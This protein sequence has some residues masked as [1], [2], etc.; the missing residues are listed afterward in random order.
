MTGRVG[1]RPDIRRYR[2]A[3]LTVLVALSIALWPEVLGPFARAYVRLCAFVPQRLPVGL[4]HH[5]PYVVATIL[6]AV[7]TL[8]VLSGFLLLRQLVRQRRMTAVLTPR[9]SSSEGHC[10]GIAAA[11]GVDGRLVIVDDRAVYAFCAGLLSPRIYL[12][13]GLVGMLEPSELA[14]VLHHEAAHIRQHDPLRLFLSDLLEWFTA[15][16]PVLRTLIAR[17]RIRIELAADQAALAVVP[18]DVLASALLKV[19]RARSAPEYT[20][21]VAGL[22]PSD[23]R[24]A[25]LA[26]RPVTIPLSRQ[27]LLVTFLVVLSLLAVLVNLAGL[28]IPK[29]PV[30]DSCPPF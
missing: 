27:D 15:P 14:A 3:V 24:I 8:A 2:V 11:A 9:H 5:P 29:V 17:F 1:L 16:F 26:G 10:V 6:L 18:P 23:A 30:C 20:A 25:V 22:T 28:P 19:A 12:S 7:A 4:H 21:A 13:Q